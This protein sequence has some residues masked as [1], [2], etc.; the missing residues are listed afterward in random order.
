MSDTIEIGER[1]RRPTGSKLAYRVVR[2]V[3]FDNH[4]PH[5]TL[6]SENADRRTITIGVG[7]LL[8]RRQWVRTE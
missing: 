3:E 8:D 4:P 5:V 2:M 1:F 6:V 7:V